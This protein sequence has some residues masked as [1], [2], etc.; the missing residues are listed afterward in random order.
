MAFCTKC[1]AEVS[2]S[3]KF[4]RGCGAALLTRVTPSVAIKRKDRGITLLLAILL[5]LIG[6]YGMGHVYLG[7]VGRG[8]VFLIADWFISIIAAVLLFVIWPIAILLFIGSLILFFWQIFDANSLVQ[9]YNK[10]LEETGSA[11]W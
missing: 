4:C 5:G 10:V 11:P 7:R 1:G 6:F 2:E 9:H 3:D 8:I